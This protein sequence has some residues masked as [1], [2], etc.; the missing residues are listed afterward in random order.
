[1]KKLK[2]IISIFTLGFIA[3]L[4]S[5]CGDSIKEFKFDNNYVTLFVG[6]ERNITS[7]KN[8]GELTYFS[9]DESVATVDNNG[10]VKGISAGNSP[11]YALFKN[12][13]YV[14]QVKVVE[15]EEEPVVYQNDVNFNTDLNMPLLGDVLIKLPMAI[16]YNTKDGLFD[17]N[18]FRF[19]LKADLMKAPET[20]GDNPISSAEQVKK[21]I[22]YINLVLGLLKSVANVNIPSEVIDYFSALNTKLQDTKAADLEKTI[23]DYGK[24]I[25]YAYLSNDYMAFGIFDNDKVKYYTFDK[26]QE[27]NI[28]NKIT[29]I[30]NL[31]KN[32]DTSDSGLQKIDV[33]GLTK[34]YN[35]DLLTEEMLT[36][37]RNA[38]TKLDKIINTAVKLL[39][40]LFGNIQVNKSNINNDENQVR[41]LFK[42]LDS[43]IE[44]L[45]T[46][47]STSTIGSMLK[48][49]SLEASADF[50]RN[51]DTY[52]NHFKGFNIN[53]IADMLG[54]DTPMNISLNL[55][56]ST[57][58]EANAFAMAENHAKYEQEANNTKGAN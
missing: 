3:I 56:D 34:S 58:V 4:L 12:K 9:G 36:Q 21:N 16:S 44:A 10:L 52:Y 33:I 35:G 54:K 22:M 17:F 20:K 19:E 55:G 39:K 6:E 47:L 43:G 8:N 5:S 53:A 48:F 31:L 15:K 25:V 11:I 30:F 24:Q 41:L 1:M 27:N 49:K 51:K 29:N 37:L 45:N 38:Y 42:L 32:I 14:C 40:Y 7:L 28:V 18:K 57:K 2:A 13:P 50:Y 23:A 26:S 46:E